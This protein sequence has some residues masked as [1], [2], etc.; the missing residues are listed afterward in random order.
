MFEPNFRYTD[1]IVNRLV[2][3]TSARD[4]VVNAYLVPKWEVSLQRDALLRSAHASTSIEGNPL[5]LE[6]VTELA[7][8]REVLATR[9]AKQEVLNYLEVLEGIEGYL[10]NGAITEETVLNLHTAVSKEVLDDPRNEG[11]YR[12]VRVYVGNS[13]TGEV[14]FMPPPPSNVKGL[15]AD[16]IE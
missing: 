6:E 13:V 12:K 8:G 16:L 11:R 14:I 2:E 1:S 5:S 15:M 9:R 3:I 7:K 10:V 4:A